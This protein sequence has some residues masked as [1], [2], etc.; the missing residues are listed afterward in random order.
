M[1]APPIAAPS[2]L[3]PPPGFSVTRLVFLRV[4]ALVYCQAFLSLYVQWPGLYSCAGLEPVHTHLQKVLQTH[5]RSGALAAVPSLVWLHDS[6]WVG[7]DVDTWC[8]MLCLAGVAL[9]G[10]LLLLGS[11]SGWGFSLCLVLYSS[12]QAVGQ[13]FLSFQWDAL[14]L[15]TGVLALL[16]TAW[17]KPTASVGMF[18]T[19]DRR[20]AQRAAQ[21][22]LLAPAN[23]ATASSSCVNST[24]PCSWSD[25]LRRFLPSS[26]HNTY[27]LGLWLLRFLLFRLMFASGVVKI[28]SECP[29]WN[30]RL[31]A[32]EYHYAT[33]CLPTPL[34]WWVHQMPRGVQQ[35]SV[36]ATIF[37]E[38]VG[39]VLV[40]VPA[41]MRSMDFVRQLTAAMQFGLQVL[42][43]ATG[44]YT[45]FNLLTIALVCTMITDEEWTAIARAVRPW[46]WSSGSGKRATQQHSAHRAHVKKGHEEKEV[47]MVGK[48]PASSS[49]SS[50]S[51]SSA[52]LAPA[53][54][55]T[56]SS[57][58]RFLWFV[59]CS[60]CK[61]SVLLGLVWAFQRMYNINVASGAELRSGLE[62]A[63]EAAGSLWTLPLAQWPYGVVLVLYPLGSLVELSPSFT[64]KV[65]QRW[66][67][68]SLL[69]ILAFAAASWGVTVLWSLGCVLARF[70]RR[71][72]AQGRMLQ[73]ARKRLLPRWVH[74]SWL[75]GLL[76]RQLLQFV[77]AAALG[78]ALFAV[79]TVPFV[80]SLS[81]PLMSSL[82][83]SRALADLYMEIQPYHIVSSYG[84][85]R[86]M[87]GVGP[88]LNVA[89]ASGMI[90]AAP[91]RT[92]QVSRPELHLEGS[93]DDG[94]SW[95][96]IRFAHKPS[97]NHSLSPTWPALLQFGH[98]P[99]LDWQ[100]WFAAL[101][102]SPPAWLVHLVWKILEGAGEHVEPSV[103]SSAAA[104]K[105]R[106][107]NPVGSLPPLPPVAPTKRHP[108]WDLLAEGGAF[109]PS[110]P[111]A[112]VRI[113]KE[114]LDFT[115]LEGAD[116]GRNA[117]ARAKSRMKRATTP[118]G[119]LSVPRDWWV[120]TSPP[121]EFLP[122]IDLSNPS[123]QNYLA[124]QHW[125]AVC[126]RM[127]S[128]TIRARAKQT[129]EAIFEAVPEGV[130]AARAEAAAAAAKA[131]GESNPS[132]SES[133]SAPT[134]VFPLTSRPWHLSFYL[135][136]LERTL[137]SPSRHAPAASAIKRAVR[138]ARVQLQQLRGL[139]SAAA[140]QGGVAGW[141]EL[142]LRS[143]LVQ[144]AGATAL[145]IILVDMLFTPA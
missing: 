34:A 79:S 87:T 58:V 40:L 13:T 6:A 72:A 124:S 75:L 16:V 85:F 83:Y 24:A 25:L 65:M 10:L 9:S 39:A 62:S 92:S 81:Q 21:Q 82:P 95:H 140:T 119:A 55:A 121:S 67:D 22:R 116:G 134:H 98:Q 23:A 70:Q 52:A 15:E 126:A 59:L 103:P 3:A 97:S 42:I 77:L 36:A 4:L 19:C 71:W 139:S 48:G 112:L 115:R 68:Q 8:E 142:L 54:T 30:Q 114:S 113:T 129:K 86:R 99:R 80:N 47:E 18:G 51:A 106:Q 46:T 101:G 117:A 105:D 11:D 145:L 133:A 111:P 127:R 26:T 100:M 125:V 123:L 137:P 73:Q 28:L 29:T 138:A 104:G 43:M 76:G 96:E 60:L 107:G 17:T 33:Q 94:A 27:S 74:R 2:S 7:V 89:P 35:I 63:R 14:L 56:S 91:V 120:P 32:L 1:V 61:L 102:P 49:S 44:N 131:K 20:E 66:V 50:A 88:D 128:E 109:S 122:P 141:A 69:G 78:S 90:G 41:S 108:V 143:N 93:D 132:A 57:S 118:R 37:I 53:T 64:P 136:L 135:S 31:S 144:M 12:L 38:S 84:L 110:N 5:G 130:A 45:F